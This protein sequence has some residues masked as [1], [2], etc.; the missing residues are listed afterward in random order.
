MLEV[1]LIIASKVPIVTD[2][3]LVVIVRDDQTLDSE[4]MIRR[5]RAIEQRVAWMILFVAARRSPGPNLTGLVN[6]VKQFHYW[7][8]GAA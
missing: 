3:K 2:I 5:A 8:R 7:I 4:F 6:A 1:T